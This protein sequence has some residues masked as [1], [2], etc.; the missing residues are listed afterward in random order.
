MAMIMQLSKSQFC[1]RTFDATSWIVIAM[2]VTNNIGTQTKCAIHYLLPVLYRHT[3]V[4]YLQQTCAHQEHHQEIWQVFG[5]STILPHNFYFCFATHN[6]Y[7]VYQYIR[8]FFLF[9]HLLPVLLLVVLVAATWHWLACVLNTVKPQTTN[10]L[11]Y[12]MQRV[13]ST[14]IVNVMINKMEKTKKEDKS[15]DKLIAL[16]IQKRFSTNH[17]PWTYGGKKLDCVV[18]CATRET[19]NTW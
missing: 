11:V 4:S 12:G 1:A 13:T 7:A 2:N 19:R 6:N 14:P 8:F 15:I 18:V 17:D 16:D 9:I 5:I 10:G 3:R